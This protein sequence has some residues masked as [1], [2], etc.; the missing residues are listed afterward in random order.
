MQARLKARHPAFLAC[1]ILGALARIPTN[2][3]FTA[4]YDPDFAPRQE[5]P[6]SRQK[7]EPAHE[8]PSSPE[9]EPE[10]SADGAAFLLRA[11][12]R[13]FLL[14]DREDPDRILIPPEAPAEPP[15][16]SEPRD[17]VEFEKSLKGLRYS[18]EAYRTVREKIEK[19]IPL[20]LEPR[21]YG[22][23]AGVL[24]STSAPAPKPP[25]PEVELPT[26]GTSLSVTG[27]KVIGFQFSEKRFL[28]DQAKTGRPASTNLFDIQQEL[29]LRM[30]GKVGPKITVNVDYDDTKLNKQDI[31]V[32]YQGDAD[33]VVQ[34]VSFG[35][36]DLSLPP[37]EFVSYNK[38][39]F[40]I[41]ADIKYKGLKASFIGSRTKGTTKTKS[42]YG[43][44][45]FVAVDIL[46]TAYVRRQ[47]YDLTFGNPARLPIQSGSERVFLSRNEVGPPNVNE[48]ILTANDLA[49]QTSSFTGKFIQQIAG[50]DYTVDY[51]NGILSFR[52]ALQPGWVIAVEFTDKSGNSIQV[53]TSTA[54]TAP[55]VDNNGTCDHNLRLIKTVGDVHISTPTEVGYRRE[56]K[57]V[58]SVGQNN[59]VRDDGRGNFFLKVLDQQRNEVGPTLNPIQKYPD[60][61]SV[62]FENGTFRLLQPFAVVGDSSTIDPDV[63]APTPISKR[64]FRVEYN[65][66][67]KT[68]FL[69]PN[70]VPQSEVVLLD[71]IKL[72]RNVDY[73]ID[74]EAGFVTFFNEGR[75]RSQSEI[76][77]S[78]EVAPFI[79]T[80][81]D[82]L[83]GTRVSYD[84]TKKFT[85][86]STLLYQTGAKSQTTPQITELARSLL[87]YEVDAT[88]K[89]T[90][91]FGGFRL[92][93]F[94]GEFAQSR[95]NLNLN[96]YALID[97]MEGVKQEESA[98][99]LAQ[100]WLP[101]PNPERP[102]MDPGK[103]NSANSNTADKIEWFSED[104]KVL[105]I[106]PKAQ[107][108]A[109]E[110]QKVLRF[111]YDFTA[112]GSSE[113]AIVFPFSTTGVDLSQKTIL[114]VV[115][116]GDNSNNALN[117]TLGGIAEDAD[118]DGVFDT[119]DGKNGNPVDGILQPGEDIGW[120]YNPTAFAP[121]SIPFGG[122]N[123]KL[124]SEDLNAN[125]KLDAADFTGDHFGYSS[126]TVTGRP[127]PFF[128]A[129]DNSTHSV[130]N[131]GGG[132]NWKVLQIP[133]GISTATAN[134]WTNIKHLRISVRRQADGGA[135]SGTLKFARIAV[136]GT[137]WQRGAALDPSLPAQG[138]VASESLVVGAINNV[139]NPN[140]TPIFNAGGEASQ[141]FNDLYGSV[142]A[143][144][145][146]SNS[147]NLS[148]QALQLDFSS[149]TIVGGRYP[150][151]TTKRVFSRAI[152]ISQHRYFNFL[153]FPNADSGAG[154]PCSADGSNQK[155]NCRDH[156]FFLRAGNDTNFF[157]ARMVM[158]A[159]NWQ[160]VRIRQVDLNGDSV[161]DTWQSETP[162]V[163]I[164]TSGTPSLQQV[165]SLVVGV[166]RSS[167]VVV[168]SGLSPTSGRVWLNEIHVA[169]PVTRVGSAKKIE[170]N[171]EV[172]GWATFG[173][174][175]REV[176]RNFQ[177]PTSVVSNQDNRLDSAYLNFTRFSYFPMTFNLQRLQTDTPS[178]VLTGDLSNLINLL[179]QGKVTTW[180]GS[181]SG[182]FALGAYPRLSLGYTRNRIDYERLTRL[183]DRRTYTS[184]LQ[185]G[186]PIA[187]F[188]I[189]RSID[190]SYN[191]TQYD[192][193]F[194]ELFARKLP[195]NVDTKELTQS[196]GARLTFTPWSGSSFN[197]SY[198]LTRVSEKRSDFTGPTEIN[199]AYPKSMN[200]SVGF[201]SNYRL[202][203]WLNPQVNYQIDTIE[204]NILAVSTFVVSGS[205][206]VFQPGDIK[207][208]NRSANGSV[209]LPVTIGDITRRTRLL[210]SLT[211]INGY[212]I[213]DGD[214]WNQVEN[215]YR[216]NF[217]L[218]VRTPLRPAGPAAQ[219]HTLT[220]RDTFNSTQRWSPLEAYNI[221]GR[222]SPLKTL[223]LSNNY[224]RSI[225]R[226]DTTGT[227][228]K[229][230]STTF[231]DAVASIGQLEILLGT[232]RWMSSTQ[233][234]YKFS[235][236]K[237][238]TVGSSINTEDAFGTDLRTIIRK[239]FDTLLSYNQRVA[240]NRDLR[241]QANT[242]RTAHEDATIQLTFDIRKFRF[243]PKTDYIHD[244]TELGTG[245]KTQD[246]TVITP[247]LLVRA[248]LAL[249]RGLRLPGSAKTLL[250][251]NRIIWTSQASFAMRSSPVT[252]ADNSRLLTF[253]TSGDYEIAK[254][255]RMTLNGALSRL[256]H[257]FLKEEDFLS[258][259]FGTTL[260]FQF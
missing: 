130:I 46:D 212:Q 232:Q 139:D 257:K 23:V 224:V 32:V 63:Y 258:Y 215:T 43:N 78:Y 48:V 64:L 240:I 102:P 206:Y 20:D 14:L 3:Q 149:L 138:P 133:L 113:A 70:L 222:W 203:S 60:T 148:E 145:R 34:N 98:S 173:F 87:V 186:V 30:Q 251:T 29:Q 178:T 8:P 194:R 47:H 12:R 158:G 165:A 74:Y 187:K 184:A 86:G 49:V 193:S 121:T 117:F 112:A 27:R 246:V 88:L 9:T 72:N 50:Q 236:R 134:R 38:Q 90:R 75:I 22:P 108:S 228:S 96:G 185:Y 188:Y 233:M 131:F 16:A 237:T 110:S 54:S 223:S 61:I 205:T 201:S 19:G 53:Q 249:P 242:Q 226:S 45:Q 135:A 219:R 85:M 197:P 42:F 238:E 218:W 128:N 97:N 260:T 210:R 143:L 140:Y 13:K 141:V 216:T 118:A 24:V 245:V 234:N 180:T 79:G 229:T 26:Y 106:N 155:P 71:G 66:R 119:E 95:Q 115:M 11:P 52:Q 103:L 204:N 4:P 132:T 174:K 107:A 65:F 255:L 195:G 256:W 35:D 136:V 37:T 104:V 62:D 163:V 192:V 146:Q 241:V 259:Q 129:T 116:L 214:V 28:N 114:E 200:Q 120:T 225:Q 68:F 17:F 89:D 168:T 250:F 150:V 126:N 231:P 213:Q 176:D 5:R 142:G 166:R 122:G 239:R 177:T 220:L 127:T 99:V 2:A 123:G 21:P 208:V 243:T 55:C 217:A 209:S 244:L 230:L 40:G 10:P 211:F 196:F 160:K 171:F 151:V 153:L 76:G 39:L 109:E 221:H 92:V 167:Q 93:S 207:T 198:S 36:I 91:L 69:E 181:A 80:T 252:Q 254:N 83:L 183:D 156:E 159:P 170:A 56:L 124:D 101:A 51:V 25:P 175:Y 253:T 105:E 147:K 191:V 111:D 154:T 190:L 6:T 58:Y 169:E 77:I 67:F 44:T 162:G 1:F 94:A 161:M 59:L 182:N 125:G 227:Q 202:L 41:R 15:A 31:S 235:Q 73:F 189:P 152:D 144:Q 172:R 164:I 84:F 157:E 247:S 57:T 18:D 100:S 7:S 199:T 33:E 82:S 81:N 137:S 179:Q 248:D